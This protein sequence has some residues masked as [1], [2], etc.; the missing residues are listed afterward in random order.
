MVKKI[1]VPELCPYSCYSCSVCENSFSYT[2]FTHD[3]LKPVTNRFCSK[4]VRKR[5]N[6]Y[7]VH[8]LTRKPV[9]S[10]A[11]SQLFT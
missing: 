8:T 6:Y 2:L 10:K 3:L 7:C 1:L 9:T 11:N 4:A 5:F